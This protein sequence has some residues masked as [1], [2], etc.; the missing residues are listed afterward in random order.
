MANKQ[1]T[2]TL[3]IEIFV[4][5]SPPAFQ[6]RR[7]D[8]KIDTKDTVMNEPTLQNIDDYNTLG[9]EK[10]RVVLAVIL[11]TLIVGAIFTAAKFYFSTVS[12][13]IPTEKVGYLPV[14]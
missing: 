12:D 9:G 13:E 4:L 14:K 6:E 2:D 5:R 1:K 8:K 10:R 7:D 11:A 3:H